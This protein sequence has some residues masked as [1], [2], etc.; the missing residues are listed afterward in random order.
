M[1]LST[2]EYRFLG[3]VQVLLSVVSLGLLSEGYNKAGLFCLL[4][5]VTA[6]CF[7]NRHHAL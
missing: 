3:I 1:N 7:R 5:A 6:L 2:K 4:L